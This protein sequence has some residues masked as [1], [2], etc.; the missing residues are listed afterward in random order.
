MQAF[1]SGSHDWEISCTAKVSC[2]FSA[3]FYIPHKGDEAK[4]LE[5]RFNALSSSKTWKQLVDEQYRSA[6]SISPH[7]TLSQP[8]TNLPKG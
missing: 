7:P 2:G 8:E 3:G 5:E 6:E 4:A 1:Y